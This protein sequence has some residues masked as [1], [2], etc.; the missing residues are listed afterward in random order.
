MRGLTADYALAMAA[1]KDAGDRLMRRKGLTTWDE[2]C[3]IEAAATFA[4]IH[5]P[6][7]ET[8]PDKTQS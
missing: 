2:D 7:N 1:G 8:G 4:R 6:P 5:G 3:R